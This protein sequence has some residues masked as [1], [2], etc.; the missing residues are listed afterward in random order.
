MAQVFSADAQMNAGSVSLVGGAEETIISTNPLQVPFETAKAKV[1][2]ACTLTAGADQIAVELKLY[3][4]FNSEDLL[5]ASQTLTNN[6]GVNG[7]MSCV[8]AAADSIPDGRQVSYTLTVTQVGGADNG[9]VTAGA[10]I[11]SML[12]S[13]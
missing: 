5:L 8:I 6:S 10:F 1:I 3:R 4:N 11:E 7:G 2:A 12:I 13:G 9:A